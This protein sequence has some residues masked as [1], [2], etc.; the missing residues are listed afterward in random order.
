[1]SEEEK[2]GDEPLDVVAEAP[3]WVETPLRR[4]ETV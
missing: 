1:M 4:V 2:K 3:L